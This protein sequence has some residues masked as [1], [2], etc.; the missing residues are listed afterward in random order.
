MKVIIML[1]S[2]NVHNKGYHT[3]TFKACN[4]SY[5]DFCI[6]TFTHFGTSDIK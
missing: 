1:I 2:S 4:D 6:A 5:C 3:S